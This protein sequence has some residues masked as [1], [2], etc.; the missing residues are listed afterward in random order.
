MMRLL[1]LL[2]ALSTASAQVLPLAPWWDLPVAENLGLSAEQK[3]RLRAIADEHRGKLLEAS[4]ALRK[5][6]TVIAT[7]MKVDPVDA[8]RARE[9]IERSIV[10]RG[11]LSR[12]VAEM[13]L[14][15]RLVLNA[16]QW[17]ELEKRQA[18]PSMGLTRKS[19]KTAHQD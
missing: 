17:D 19:G 3:T 4:A 13:S 14:Q 11:R 6:E 8:A 7:L 15:M 9:A 16:K 5:E 18:A 10:A 12:A 1:L 2:I